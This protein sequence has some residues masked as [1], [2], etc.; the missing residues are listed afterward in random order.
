MRYKSFIKMLEMGVIKNRTTTL[1]SSLF[2]VIFAY[3]CQ[4]SD[5]KEGWGMLTEWLPCPRFSVRYF[6]K[7]HSH[8]GHDQQCVLHN[9]S[10]VPQ[11]LNSE[12]VGQWNETE[13]EPLIMRKGPSK[14]TLEQINNNIYL[15][16]IGQWFHEEQPYYLYQELS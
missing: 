7:I 10:R 11:K 4:T 1:R 14:K 8:G 5:R 13:G 9:N 6:V 2:Y 16:G 3:F 15:Y 12:N